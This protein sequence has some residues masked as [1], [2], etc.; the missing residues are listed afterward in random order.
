L[1][2]NASAAKPGNSITYARLFSV[3]IMHSNINPRALC[4][5]SLFFLALPANAQKLSNKPCPIL[6]AYYPPP[7][8]LGA[9]CSIASAAGETESQILAALRNGSEYGQLDAETTAFSVDVYSLYNQSSLFNYHFTPES[10]ASQ[11]TSGVASV[12]SNTVYRIG[13]VSKL[14]TVYLYLIKAGDASWNQPIT[15]FVPELATIAQKYNAS[16]NEV[17]NVSWNSITVGALASQLA[18]IGR[19]AAVSNFCTYFLTLG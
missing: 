4:A 17:D 18:G 1:S 13:S 6:G 2:C 3:F 5:A 8:D 19:D 12:D 15:N 9:S 10:L 14:W 11:R 16:N 7:T